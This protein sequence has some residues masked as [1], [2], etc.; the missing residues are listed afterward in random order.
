MIVLRPEP[1]TFLADN[2]R[3]A[4]IRAALRLLRDAWEAA[5]D[6]QVP[7]EEFA[8]EAQEL[9]RLGLTRPELRWLIG[10][11]HVVHLRETTRGRR[12]TFRRPPTPEI[13]ATSCFVLAN[14]DLLA[15]LEEEE[16]PVPPG[17]LALAPPGGTKSFLHT[18][19]WD[20][21][22]RQLLCGEMVVKSFRV[23]APNQ[24]LILAALEEEG[25]PAQI[26]D[27]LPIVHD[28]NPKARLHDTIKGLNRNQVHRLLR[29]VG[30]GTGR[31]VGWRLLDAGG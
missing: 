4:R 8:I 25:W 7:T 29:F 10:K 30:D 3:R 6:L 2:A 11:G 9:F 22:Q 13:S 12:R 17:P 1:G 24:E 14:T 28:V 27:P 19:H 5:H 20:G 31:A 23:P 21:E 26:D 15:V 18:P 16:Q